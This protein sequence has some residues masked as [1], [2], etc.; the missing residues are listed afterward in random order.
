M[1]KKLKLKSKKTIVILVTLLVILIVGFIVYLFIKDDENQIIE[2]EKTGYTLNDLNDKFNE[3]NDTCSSTIEDDYLLVTC[4]NNDYFEFSIVNN[5]LEVKSSNEEVKTV[6]RE[7][8]LTIQSFYE[9]DYT[10]FEETVD[11]F[12]DNLIKVTYLNYSLEDSVYYYNVKLSESIAVYE[13]EVEYE[14]S[15]NIVVTDDVIEISYSN[16]DV[17]INNAF[18]YYVEDYG[19][20]CF[21]GNLTSSIDLVTLVFDLYDKEDNLIKTIYHTVDKEED[22]LR[23]FEIVDDISEFSEEVSYIQIS[24]LELY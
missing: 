22:S 17:I 23:E 10:I 1:R 2:I 7:M 14:D 5:Y 24:T 8:V 18:A 11:L 9:E 21:G 6:Y 4:N 19:Y 15:E 16:V 13:P 20:F 3:L 12:I